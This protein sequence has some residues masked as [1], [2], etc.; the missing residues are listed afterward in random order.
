MYYVDEENVQIFYQL[1]E[2][3]K[4]EVLEYDEK[5][6]NTDFLKKWKEKFNED[7]PENEMCLYVG[8]PG[9]MGN[10]YDWYEDFFYKENP[11]DESEAEKLIKEI[12]ERVNVN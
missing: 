4:I 9:E 1:V 11:E 7:Y 12:Q 3:G 8:I 5:G 10:F 6:I 2:E